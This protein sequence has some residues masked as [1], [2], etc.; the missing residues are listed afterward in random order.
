MAAD[1]APASF[2]NAARLKPCIITPT[3]P[4]ET[5]ASGVN[6][7]LKINAKASSTHSTLEIIM[8]IVDM[9]PLRFGLHPDLGMH[10]E[11]L[12]HQQMFIL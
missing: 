11:T 9:K 2:E 12:L 5:V 1:P 8:K 7:F 4:P 6:A 3:I 10:F